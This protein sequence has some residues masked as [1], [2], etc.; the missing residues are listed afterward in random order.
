[1]L[2]WKDL[3]TLFMQVDGNFIFLNGPYSFY[4]N[5]VT[6]FVEGVETQVTDSMQLETLINSWVNDCNTDAV[7]PA[8]VTVSDVEQMY[9]ETSLQK[10]WVVTNSDGSVVIYDDVQL[11]NVSSTTN[12]VPNIPNSDN[13]TTHDYVDSII[14]ENTLLAISGGKFV[15]AMHVVPKGK[16]VTITMGGGTS[17]IEMGRGVQFGL[18]DEIPL[19]K[20][21]RINNPNGV[22]IHIVNDW[23]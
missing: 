21:W 3:K 22:K 1:M 11:T 16:G 13:V 7:I 23:E 9:G 20:G 15:D 5:N 2:G 10:V 17:P 6:L 19:I 18:N 14:D 4:S 12:V 8:Q